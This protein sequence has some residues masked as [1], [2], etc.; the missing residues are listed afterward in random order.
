MGSAVVAHALQHVE[1]SWTRDGTRVP[2]ICTWILIHCATREDPPEFFR[3]DSGNKSR[4]SPT[5]KLE[6]ILSL[7]PSTYNIHLQR[8]FIFPPQYLLSLFLPLVYFQTHHNSPK[9]EQSLLTDLPTSD[10]ALAKSISILYR[11]D[12]VRH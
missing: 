10:L 7:P 4:Y 8:L 5:R 9:P 12:I 6:S 11:A 3:S 1:S 2:C